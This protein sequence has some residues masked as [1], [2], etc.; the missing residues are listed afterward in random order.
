MESSSK[1]QF[2][3]RYEEFKKTYANNKIVL[4]YVE[5]G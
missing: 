4:A 3:L 2:N 1:E 5:E